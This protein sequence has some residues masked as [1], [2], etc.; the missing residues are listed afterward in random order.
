M[1]ETPQAKPK[2]I[3]VNIPVTDLARSVAFY[4]AVGAAKNPQF[5]DDTG[6]CMVISETIYVMLLTHDKFKSFCSK[7][8]IDAKKGVEALFC[9][10]ENS[11]A[12]VDT[13]IDRAWGAGGKADPTAKQ[14][15]GFMY[16]R[17]FEDP[18]GH[19]WEVVWMDVAA[20]EQAQ[21]QTAA[22]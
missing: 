3:F 9:L 1:S 12:D 8:I 13:M 11:R 16:S 5:S 19:I 22:A 7:P 17:S 4:E 20:F 15:H 10:S 21:Q 14:D 2:M 18:D 6:A